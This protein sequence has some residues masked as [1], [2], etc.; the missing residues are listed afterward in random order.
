MNEKPNNTPDRLLREAA[1]LYIDKLGEDLLSEA[2]SAYGPPLHL[3]VVNRVSQ[4]IKT[5]RRSAGLKKISAAL[6]P[7]AACFIFLIIYFTR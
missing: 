6:L 1:S 2:N 3:S 5:K 7:A 4:K